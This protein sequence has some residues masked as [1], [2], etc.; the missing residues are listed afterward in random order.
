MSNISSKEIIIKY[1]E[2]KNLQNI[3]KKREKNSHKGDFGT[4]SIIGG[5]RGMEGSVLLAA[6]TAIKIG[7]GKVLIGFTQKNIPITVDL[8][9][10]ELM[11]QTANQILKKFLIKIDTWI[12]GCGMGQNNISNNILHKA[13]SYIENKNIVLDADALNIISEQNTIYKNSSN[14]IIMTPHPSEAAR[15][16][17]C[18]T[19]EIQ[20][21]RI[22]SAKKISKIYNSW[23]VL[24]GFE[25][26]ISS[27][28]GDILI[29][30]SGNPGLAS[31]GTGDVLAGMIGSF[32]GQSNDIQQAISGAVWLHGKAAEHLASIHKGPIGMTASELAEAAREILNQHSYQN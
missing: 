6:R 29:N 3:F 24:K 10:P 27:P 9:Q 14:T 17:K 21:N 13:L 11:L 2:P 19:K 5:N 31:S 4:I 8:I 25:T 1:V 16:L 18:T 22:K 23:T 7:S 32:L 12:I 26:I 20:S 28:N 30:T 15:L